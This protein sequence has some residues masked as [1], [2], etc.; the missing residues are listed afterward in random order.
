[1]V[2]PPCRALYRV[3]RSPNV[4]AATDIS[5]TICFACACGAVGRRVH[6]GPAPSSPRA[7][8][9]RSLAAAR[10]AAWPTCSSPGPPPR[11]SSRKVICPAASAGSNRCCSRRRPTKPSR[12]PAISPLSSSYRVGDPLESSP[13]ALCGSNRTS[14]GPAA[15]NCGNKN[16]S[17]WCSSVS[18]YWR[19]ILRPAGCTAVPGPR[20]PVPARLPAIPGKRISAKAGGPP[21][22]HAGRP[23]QHQWHPC[24]RQSLAQPATAACDVLAP[25]E[26]HARHVTLLEQRG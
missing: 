25:I 19:A 5:L 16:V 23:A 9:S 22:S 21:V 24:S 26:E 11:A 20:P 1:M 17:S 18:G 12:N 6:R 14:S 4:M 7:R 2:Y 13:A 10:P 15:Y 8:Q 3:R